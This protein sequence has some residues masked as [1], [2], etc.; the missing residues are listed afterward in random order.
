MNKN[1]LIPAAALLLFGGA[2]LVTSNAF[3][4]NA[5]VNTYPTIVQKLVDRFGL[6]AEEVQQ[7]FDEERDE[8]HAKMQ[9]MMESR[10][11]E[12]VTNGELTEEQKQLILQK[13]EEMQTE[14]EQNREVFQN[15]TDEERRTAMEEKHDELEAWAKSNGIDLQY[16]M[17]QMKAGG[18]GMHHGWMHE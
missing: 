9:E 14:R 15:M 4:Q 17:F 11:T 8:H 2:A 5:T 7:V 13:Q 1:I 16:L 10:L 18:F 6:N 3:A 12:A